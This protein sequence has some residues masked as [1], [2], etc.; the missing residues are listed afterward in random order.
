MEVVISNRHGAKANEKNKTCVNKE[1]LQ[2]FS[3]LF[4]IHVKKKLYIKFLKEIIN[5]II[6]ITANMK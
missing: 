6:I 5:Y 3:D 4:K 2:Y 1:H